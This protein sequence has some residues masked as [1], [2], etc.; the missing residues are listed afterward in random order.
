MISLL[1]TICTAFFTL[2]G[3]VFWFSVFRP[4]KENRVIT[5]LGFDTSNRLNRLRLLWL[6]MRRPWIFVVMF[7]FLTMD[8]HEQALYIN[9]IRERKK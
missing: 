2:T 4:I 9:K 3:I 1:S 7:A 6:A 8:E 5:E